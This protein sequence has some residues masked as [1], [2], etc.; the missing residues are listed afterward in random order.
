MDNNENSNRTNDSNKSTSISPLRR[1]EKSMEIDYEK[2]HEGIGYDVEAI[3]AAFS[4][5]HKAIVQ[6]LINHSVK[7]HCNMLK[8]S[9]ASHK[10]LTILRN[11]IQR[12]QRK[13]LFAG[14]LSREGVIAILFE[15]MLFYLHG[16]TNSP[17]T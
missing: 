11:I 6:I 10:F 4:T 7:T 12:K 17:L 2:W 9:V 15:A 14:L 8:Y 13:H 3:G 1:F 5:E 16:K